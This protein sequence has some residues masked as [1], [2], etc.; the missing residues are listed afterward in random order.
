MTV[1]FVRRGYTVGYDDSATASTGCPV[2]FDELLKQQRRW[3]PGLARG[4]LLGAFAGTET[5]LETD[6]ML[7]YSTITL[8]S[9]GYGEVVPTTSH[10]RLLAGL[11]GV[12]GQIYMA[13]L[14][15][16]LVGLEIE[17]RDDEQAP[18]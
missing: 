15:A 17:P 14:V 7:Y 12:L 4:S 13:V 8:T 18:T 2:T 10:G 3:L 11:Q 6:L 16:Y 1:E 5:I 9:V